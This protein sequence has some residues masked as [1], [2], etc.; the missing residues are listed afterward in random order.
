VNEVEELLKL[1]TTYGFPM[2]VA[3][4]L[5]IRMELKLTVLNEAITKLSEVIAECRFTNSLKVA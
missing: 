4:Y 5:L 1:I 2:V 3:V